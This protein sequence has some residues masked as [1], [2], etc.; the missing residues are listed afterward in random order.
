MTLPP[1]AQFVGVL[2]TTVAEVITAEHQKCK[3]ALPPGQHILTL[4][5]LAHFPSCRLSGV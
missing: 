5:Q 1:Q 3:S 2:Q 4:L